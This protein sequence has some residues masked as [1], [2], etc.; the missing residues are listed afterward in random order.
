MSKYPRALLRCCIPALIT[1]GLSFWLA[2]ACVSFFCPCLMFN[3]T[4]GILL[5]GAIAAVLTIIP[6]TLLARLLQGK[7]CPVAAAGI[8]GALAAIIFLQ[9]QELQILRRQMNIQP[10]P[11]ASGLG[12]TAEYPFVWPNENSSLLFH[13]SADSPRHMWCSD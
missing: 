1:L 2:S 4:T 12:A 13:E 6:G 11:P 8:T 9:Q 10:G 3:S 5:V 7:V